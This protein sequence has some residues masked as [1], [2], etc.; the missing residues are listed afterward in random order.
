MAIF[1]S[2]ITLD[3]IQRREKTLKKLL[4]IIYCVRDLCRCPVTE[5][6]TSA[7]FLRPATARY[8]AW[9]PGDAL[10]PWSTALSWQ[11]HDGCHA[12][13]RLSISHWRVRYHRRSHL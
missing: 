9:S 5:R 10:C 1:N 4:K 7:I 8:R 6:M 11:R 2:P 3:N 13:Q 12:D